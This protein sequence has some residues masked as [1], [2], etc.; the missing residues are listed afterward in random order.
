MHQ[1]SHFKIPFL[2]TRQYFVWLHCHAYQVCIPF[3]VYHLSFVY[4]SKLFT[5]HQMTKNNKLHGY[6]CCCGMLFF[7]KINK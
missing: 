5:P 6:F 2:N 3:F 1:C 7:L 4:T